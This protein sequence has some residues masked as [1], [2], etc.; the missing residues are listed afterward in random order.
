MHFT[1]NILLEVTKMVDK[2][3]C[4]WYKK[5]FDYEQDKNEQHGDC[6]YC[7]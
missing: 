6:C 7:K 4:P 1:T 5:L 3:S 2:I